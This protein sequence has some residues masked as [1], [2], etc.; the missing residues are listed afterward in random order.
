MSEVVPPEAHIARLEA[1]S[2]PWWPVPPHPGEDAPNVVVILFDDT[3]FAHLGCYGSDMRHPEHRPTR[4][5]RA[6][7]HELPR[8]PAVLAD[9]GRAAHRP[10]P[11][12]G[13]HAGR[14]PTST[15][16]IPH[17]RGHISDHAGDRWPRCCATRATRPSRVGKWHLCPMERGLGGRPLRPVAAASAASTASTASSTARP[18][19]S[20]P[21]WSTTTTRVDPPRGARGRLPP[22]RGP[23]RPG[24]RLHPRLGLDPPRPAVLHLPRARRDARAAPGA[25]RVP[26]ASTGAA[27]TTGWDV[28]RERWFARQK[29]LGIVPAGHRAGAR[30]TPASRRGTTMPENHRRLAARLQEAFAAFLDHTDEQIGRLVDALE[31]LDLLDDTIIVL[32]SDNGA[33]QEGGP[34]RRHARDE[35]LQLPP[36]DPRRGHRA[37]RRHRWTAQPRQLPVGLGAGRQ[38]ARSSGTSRTPTRAACTCRCIVHWPAGIADRRRP[39][40]TSSTTSTTSCRRSTSCS[41]S[42]PPETYRGRRPAARHGHLDGLHASTP[43]RPPSPA[44]ST[45]STSR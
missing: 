30:A 22:H 28:A 25:G 14:C 10:Q 17:M 39:S 21:S 13:R 11:P 23:G 43:T 20:T 24:H 7:L 9:A 36:R 3:G 4:R 5:G 26:R 18:T 27:S 34:V 37:P 38:H 29:E 32:L 1:D 2:T 42:T 44:G 8:H 6:A 15:P 31:R 35:V 12:H 19:S 33:S 45:S 41:A 40:A 16:A